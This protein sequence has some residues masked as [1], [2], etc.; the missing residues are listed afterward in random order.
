M[1]DRKHFCATYYPINFQV[2]WIKIDPFLDGFLIEIDI[3]QSLVVSL[4]EPVDFVL[5]V[6]A[7]SVDLFFGQPF[8]MK[9]AS[10]FV[11]DQVFLLSWILS[12]SSP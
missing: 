3:G 2:A 12:I 9:V 6:F 11:F 7:Q 10:S 4:V 1:D 8:C 5:H